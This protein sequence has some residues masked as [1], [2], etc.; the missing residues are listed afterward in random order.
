MFSI[1][2]QLSILIGFVRWLIPSQGRSVRFYF[3][4]LNV[5]IGSRQSVYRHFRELKAAGGRA[6][7]KDFLRAL[8]AVSDS[9]K[10]SVPATLL[11]RLLRTIYLTDVVPGK[12]YGDRH[13]GPNQGYIDHPQFSYGDSLQSFMRPKTKTGELP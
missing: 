3:S 1:L 13:G 11:A 6:R 7:F 10:T 12:D 9:G 8:A 2:K 5:L 4:L